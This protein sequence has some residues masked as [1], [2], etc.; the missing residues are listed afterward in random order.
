MVRMRNSALKTRP[1]PQADRSNIGRAKIDNP[2][3]SCPKKGV[4]P[5]DPP[6]GNGG[7]RGDGPSNPFW[8]IVSALAV[9]IGSVFGAKFL[10][11]YGAEAVIAVMFCLA[12]WT[13]VLAA[14]RGMR[15]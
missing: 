14:F 7:G 11:L 12:V 13:S 6:K 10:G 9:V 2:A 5:P 3:D 4:A 1:R 8:V 15:G